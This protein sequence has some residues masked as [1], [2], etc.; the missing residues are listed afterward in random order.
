MHLAFFKAP[1]S[2]SDKLALF[3]ILS[4]EGSTTV[5]GKLSKA[6][7]PRIFRLAE[8]RTSESL[9]EEDIVNDSI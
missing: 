6:M 2:S 8:T 7:T 3:S 1:S 5:N 9:E 4:H